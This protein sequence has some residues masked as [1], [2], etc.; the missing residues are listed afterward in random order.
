[1]GS[2]QPLLFTS[3]HPPRSLLPSDPRPSTPISP[4]QSSTHMSLFTMGTVDRDSAMSQG[5]GQCVAQSRARCQGAV[6][7][8]GQNQGTLKCSLGLI[9][10]KG[11]NSWL[12]GRNE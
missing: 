7:T 9:P 12:S 4:V 5:L 1:M 6:V 10:S 11:G 2:C 3:T 8:L